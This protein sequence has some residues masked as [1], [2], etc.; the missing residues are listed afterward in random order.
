MRRIENENDRPKSLV[1]IYISY[2]L[3]FEVS[4]KTKKCSQPAKYKW[5]IER[6]IAKIG[7]NVYIIYKRGI[8]I[9]DVAKLHREKVKIGPGK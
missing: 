1:Y 6:V 2:I 8:V 3:A 5:Y 9:I 7:E 4:K